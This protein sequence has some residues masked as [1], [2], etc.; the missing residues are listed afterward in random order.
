MGSDNEWLP[1]WVLGVADCDD[2]WE[3]GCY[4]DAVLAFG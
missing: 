4:L 3:V 2:P 1:G